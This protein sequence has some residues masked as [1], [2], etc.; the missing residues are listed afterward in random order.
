MQ[1][2][3]QAGEQHYDETGGKHELVAGGRQRRI[4]SLPHIS[5]E[6]DGLRKHAI[7]QPLQV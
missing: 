7:N 1:S 2:K 3:G 6:V 4:E 5:G